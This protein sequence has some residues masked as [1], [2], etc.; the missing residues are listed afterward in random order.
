[1][2]NDP[3]RL[4]VLRRQLLLDSSAERA[5]DDITRLLADSLDVPIAIVNLLD[6]DRDWFK[7]CVG[8]P[9]QESATATSFCEVFF[10]KTDDVIVVEDTLGDARFAAH[11]MVVGAPFVRF[12]SAARLTVD[13]Q[14]I[15]TLC[16]YDLKPRRV[17]TEQISQL[18][19]L[20]NA[21]V[22]SI[23]ARSRLPG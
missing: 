13:E 20:A 15:G 19:T 14:T 16:A 9:L 7:S 6:A 11:P 12:Y 10:H 1:M 8:L 2:R 23:K 4:A 21:V 3:S 22:A 17:A 5:F 18:Q